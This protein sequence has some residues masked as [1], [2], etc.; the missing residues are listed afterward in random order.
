MLYIKKSDKINY[1]FYFLVVRDFDHDIKLL[2]EFLLTS[3]DFRLFDLERSV[4]LIIKYYYVLLCII[5]YYYDHCVLCIMYYVLYMCSY[6]GM[7][8]NIIMTE[9]IEL[10]K[11]S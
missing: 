11:N 7:I 2:K 6:Y 9:N 5:M 10:S 8:N 1:K 3:T 4:I